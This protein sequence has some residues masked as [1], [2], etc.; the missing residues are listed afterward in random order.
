M[1][2]SY[3]FYSYEEDN[4]AID[5]VTADT[6]D[7]VLFTGEKAPDDSIHVFGVSVLYQLP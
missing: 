7:K 3:Q 1:T 4:W 5:G 2:F 6:M